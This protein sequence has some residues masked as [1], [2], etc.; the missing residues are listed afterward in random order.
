MFQYLAMCCEC[1]FECVTGESGSVQSG[2]IEVIVSNKY[3]TVFDDKFTFEVVV[4]LFVVFTELL[5]L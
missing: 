1:S 4:L 2:T 3:T 5:A